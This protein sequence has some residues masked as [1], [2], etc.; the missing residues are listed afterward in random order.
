[1]I[2]YVVAQSP[3]SFAAW[4]RNEARPLV[5]PTSAQAKRGEQIFLSTTCAQCHA[6]RG[7]TANGNVGP[8]LTHLAGR[9]TIASGTLPNDTG[10]LTDWIRH[11]QTIKQGTLMPSAP[12]SQNDIDAV[13]AF[14]EG[15]H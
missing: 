2:F 13:V 9:R 10:D 14:L 4:E 8:D 15:L 7:T 5:Q 12:L 11:P 6:I 3:P 1:M